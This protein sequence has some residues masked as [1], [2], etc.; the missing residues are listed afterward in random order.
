VRALTGDSTVADDGLLLVAAAAALE[1]GEP[2]VGV[3][4]WPEVVEDDCWPEPR[5][6]TVRRAF[7]RGLHVCAP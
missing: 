6:M 5:A 7:A 3:G 1:T 4:A 2:G